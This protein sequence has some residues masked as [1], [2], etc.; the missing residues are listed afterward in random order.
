MTAPPGGGCQCTSINAWI[1]WLLGER[2]L[3]MPVNESFAP[4]NADLVAAGMKSLLRPCLDS[5][6]LRGWGG[7]RTA[8]SSAV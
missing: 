8:Y 6:R 5:R 2:M 7:C 1:A 3:Q 4:T